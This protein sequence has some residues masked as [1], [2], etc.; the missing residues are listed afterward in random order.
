VAGYIVS[1]LGHVPVVGESCAF[2]G[3]VLT[4]VGVDGRRVS[5]VRVSV[6]PEVTLQ[7]ELPG[8]DSSAPETDTGPGAAAKSG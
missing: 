4:V 6:R 2:D 7:I 8:S 5:R 1:R 3:H